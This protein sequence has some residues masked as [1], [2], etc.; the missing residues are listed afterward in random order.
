MNKYAEILRANK[1]FGAL[2]EK[3]IA[4]ISGAA[5]SNIVRFKAGETIYSSE[6]FRKAVGIVLSGKVKVSRR[7]DKNVLLNTLLAG[8]VFGV[9]GLFGPD[10]EAGDVGKDSVSGVFV[11][12][13]RGGAAG[14]IWFIDGVTVRRFLRENPEFAES[15]IRFLSDKVRFLN[16]RIA[17]FTAQGA[18]AKVAGYLLD[19]EGKPAAVKNMSA[20][21]KSLNIGRA[22]LYRVLDCMEKKG[23]IRRTGGAIVI[24]DR[25]ELLKLSGRKCGK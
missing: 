4:E 10:G 2:S 20:L 5:E 12:E 8:D 14:R 17:D 19:A 11:S 22:S 18:E 23:I 7:N 24:T 1:L 3:Q 16:D 6:G 15:Y 9:A 25:E 13:I 21:A